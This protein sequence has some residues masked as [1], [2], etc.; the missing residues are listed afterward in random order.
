L[1][2]I[3]RL[4]PDE[5]IQESLHFLTNFLVPVAV[6]SILFFAIYQGLPNRTIKSGPSFLA[7]VIAG[8]AFQILQYYYFNIQMS[9]SAY[10]SIYGS[11]AAL[12]LL[13]IWLRMSWVIILFGA[14]LAYG[15]EHER[16]F[17][18]SQQ[19]RQPSHNP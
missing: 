5:T 19:S 12:P 14:E 10:N 2:N 1:S 4:I 16:D 8:T 3:I 9:I 15:I 17:T 6:F 11:F 13:L 7:A 18:S